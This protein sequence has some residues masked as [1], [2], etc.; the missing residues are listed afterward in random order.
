MPEPTPPSPPPLRPALHA[1]DTLLSRLLDG[2]YPPGS[3][4]PAERDLAAQLGVTRPTLREALQRLER[5]GLLEIRQ[6]KPTR[7]LHPHEGGL[8]VLAHLSR[9]G[10]LRGLVPDLLD[11]RAALLPYWVAQ[12]AARDPATLREHLGAPP[13]ESTDPALPVT[14]ATFDWTFQTLAAQGSGNA[15]APLLL[16]AFHEVYARAGAI[17]FSDATRRER[18][19]E[20]YRALHAALPLGA[21]TAGHVA[22]TTS[23]DSLTLWEARGV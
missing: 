18:S 12:T 3:T 14:F 23:L 1:E 20:H 7:V 4:L 16:G 10:D 6:G 2:T 8:R 11:L 15:L 13:A 21:A 5:D 22:R 9:H 17:Y 19:R